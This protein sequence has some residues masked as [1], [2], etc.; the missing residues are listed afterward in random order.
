M[1]TQKIV[2]II[3]FIFI[4]LLSILALLLAYIHLSIIMTLSGVLG[5]I[6]LKIFLYPKIIKYTKKKNIVNHINTKKLDIIWNDDYNWFC[7]N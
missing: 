4:A 6:S 3:A 1:K 2:A 7:K 5:L